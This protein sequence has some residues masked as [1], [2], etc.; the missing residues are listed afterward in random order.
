MSHR[1]V[2]LALLFFSMWT[3]AFSVRS[4]ALQTLSP[5]TIKAGIFHFEVPEN[6]RVTRGRTLR[7]KYRIVNHERNRPTLFYFTGGPG[8]SNLKHSFPRARRQNFT[9]IQVGYRGIDSDAVL[10][11]PELVVQI[12]SARLLSGSS[13]NNRALI[14]NQCVDAWKA[15]GLDLAG[16]QLRDVANDAEDL[17]QFL[18]LGRI[19]ILA[20]SFGT[21]VAQIYASLFPGSIERLV[22]V[23]ANPPGHFYWSKND[24]ATSFSA[25]E[26]FL[27]TT[28]LES[29]FASTLTN[30][31]SSSWGIDIDVDRIRAISFFMLFHR[32]TSAFVLGALERAER[33]RSYWRM[34]ALT[35]AYDWLLPRS[36]DEWGDLFWKGLIT[37]WDPTFD[38]VQDSK[39]TE[40]RFG[41]P[42]G[43][44]LFSPPYDPSFLVYKDPQIEIKLSMPTLIV[45]GGLDFSTPASNA[46]KLI[47]DS[48]GATQVVFPS[49]GHV[50]DFW[51]QDRAFSTL[52]SKFFTHGIVPVATD[53]P[54]L[55]DKN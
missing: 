15:Q 16:Y 17:R 50:G 25:Y 30:L 11:C 44:L 38:Y 24:I 10:S 39:M 37:D 5:L 28:A 49:Y 35:K 52:L 12:Q 14:F 20:D 45:S 2:A 34:A 33:D 22:L 9:I 4:S 3:T 31:P 19:N 43:D 46:L 8:M 51:S 23:G 48:N 32:K 36:M 41:S 27:G 21:R 54:S 1:Y 47:T 40:N 6:R 26:E 42:L 13:R 53:L 7:L 29:R 55:I 18:S